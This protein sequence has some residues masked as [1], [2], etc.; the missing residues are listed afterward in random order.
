MHV[1]QA[2]CD[3]PAVQRRFF[4]A[5]P[6]LLLAAIAAVLPSPAAA[7]G[8]IIAPAARNYVRNWNWCPHCVNGGGPA[9]TSRGGQLTWPASAAA[10]CGD[11]SLAT[12]GAPVATYHAGSVI[13]IQLFITAQHGGRHV[14]RLCPGPN[15]TSACLTA[16]GA[17]LQRADGAGPFSWTPREGGPSPAPSAG[18]YARAI[19]AGIGGELYAWRYRLPAG[20][21]CER[22]VLWWRWSTGNSC[23]VPGSPA[24]L[25]TGNLPA[26]GSWGAYPEEFMNCADVRI[27]VPPPSPPPRPP[28]R[29]PFPRPPPP[30]PR[31]PPPPRPRPSPPRNRPPSPPPPPVQLPPW[32]LACTA[33]KA[34][35]FCA[36][37]PA[38]DRFY[39]APGTACR[40]F[41]RCVPGFPATVYTC[42]DPLVFNQAAQYC[43]WPSYV[44]CTVA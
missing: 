26:C 30:R 27:V 43:D 17:V 1:G 11:P 15:M 36:A 37:Q 23:T 3:A 34:A 41:F 6:L 35:Q 14:F 2:A 25:S 39:A 16:P 18:T 33:A 29:L 21:T 40:C 20:V 5:V 12:A 44:T 8:F 22:C 13:N 10:A 4:A 38:V 42:D 24:W 31:P 28:L 32:M 9:A 19:R 7:H